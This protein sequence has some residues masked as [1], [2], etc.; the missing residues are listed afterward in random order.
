MGL[1]DPSLK[2]RILTEMRA[3]GCVHESSSLE[4]KHAGGREPSR[5]LISCFVMRKIAT[6]AYAEIMFRNFRALRFYPAVVAQGFGEAH[7]QNP[8]VVSDMT[9]LHHIHE[10]GILHNLGERSKLKDQRPYTFMV[11]FPCYTHMG[12]GADRLS[13]SAFR[14]LVDVLGAVHRLL[15]GTAAYSQDGRGGL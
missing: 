12:G 11:N 14:S 4:G 6:H 15:G 7:P 1:R 3:K 5:E 2:G 13:R 8:K 9:A 10:A